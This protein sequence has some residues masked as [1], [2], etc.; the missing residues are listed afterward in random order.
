M[1]KQAAASS[2]ASDTDAEMSQIFVA[3]AAAASSPGKQEVSRNGSGA[4]P[5][6]SKR[7]L[8]EKTGQV[9]DADDDDRSVKDLSLIHI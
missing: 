1:G 7:G 2:K 9:V 8:K 5:P 4:E 6:P 3:A